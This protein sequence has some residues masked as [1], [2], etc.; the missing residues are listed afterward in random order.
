MR[1]HFN[2]G[3]EVSEDN[4]L[5]LWPTEGKRIA[6]LDGDM[7]PYII[8]YTISEMTLVRAMTRVKSGQ[9][10]TIEDTPECKAACDRVN[11]L[12][13][14]WVFSADCDAA[15]IFMTSSA[16]NFRLRLA[17]SVPY[18]G[19]RKAEKP[20]FFYEMREHLLKVHGAVLA[21]GDEAD[22]L[23]S[24][25]Q[26]DAHREFLAE[27]G[28]EFDIGS[29]EHRAFSTTTIVSAD[30]DL[31]IVPGWHLIPGEEPKWVEP[32]GELHLHYS[33]GGKLKGIKGSGLK[34]FYSQMVTGD[35]V[36]AYKGIPGRG[37]K[38]AYELLHKCKDEK[39]L[40][41]AVLGAYKDKYGRGAVRINNFRG[42][43]RIGKAYDMMLESG[44]LAHMSHFSG[45]IWRQDKSTIIWG[46]DK[47]AWK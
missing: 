19:T 7:V 46:D 30:K 35:T 15:R 2:F 5:I 23:M 11:G 39:E 6:L 25:A 44:R 32:L 37:A 38:F 40:Y 29:P 31:M 17:F 43:Y 33:S 14:S 20:P 22:D 8:G 27:T 34:F 45:D 28:N 10:A 4:N 36:D 47:D 18:K 21:E 24:I 42:G 26:W 13:N 1:P 12:L 41:M 9:V 16:D 3:A